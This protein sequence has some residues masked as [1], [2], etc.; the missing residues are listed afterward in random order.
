MPVGKGQRYLADL[1]GLP[2][3][4]LGGWQINTIFVA[5]SG[6]PLGM[7]MQN[8]QSGTAFGNRPDR[9]C[10]GKLDDPTIAALVRYQLFRATG[11]GVLGNAARTTLFGPGRWNV[12]LSLSKKIDKFQFRAEVVQRVQPRAVRAAWHLGRLADLRHHP[13]DGEVLTADPVRTEVRVLKSRGGGALPLRLPAPS[14]DKPVR[15]TL[16]SVCRSLGGFITMT[17]SGHYKRALAV[18]AA[19]I[20]ISAPVLEAQQK[21]VFIDQDIGGATGTDNQSLMMLVQAPAD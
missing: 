6:Y 14:T 20:F 9:I 5:Q 17:I 21:K 8:S 19:V 15:N 4:L 2:E 13:V 7:S 18:L 12:D 1:D 10:D 3:V 16:G 11:T